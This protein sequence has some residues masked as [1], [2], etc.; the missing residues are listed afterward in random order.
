M[1]RKE[2]IQV[3]RLEDI[4]EIWSTLNEVERRYLK[5]NSELK[6]YRRGELIHV[7]GEI[8]THMMI[9]VR[10]KVKIYKK[11]IG[12]RQQIMR[13]L[14]PFALFGYRAIFADNAF[15]G[16]NTNACA[17]EDASVYLIPSEVITHL[18]SL[19]PTLAFHFVKRLADELG[20]SDARIVALTQKHV[21]A[22]LAESLLFLKDNYGTREDGKTINV[23]VSRDDIASLSNMTTSNAIR[24]LSAFA[25]EGLI[26]LSG[27]KIK[28][29]SEAELQHINTLG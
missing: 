14:K 21:R 13:M 1:R 28:I 4:T 11:G 8:P 26:E 27:R 17:F 7:E 2:P 15:H 3:P 22:R 23:L 5:M 18:L 20:A 25:N 10:G 9:L 24:T 29:I 6:H 19:N 16:Y 12:D